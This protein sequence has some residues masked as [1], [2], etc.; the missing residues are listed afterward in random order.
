MSTNYTYA[1]DDR[2]E[3]GDREAPL[4]FCTEFVKIGKKQFESRVST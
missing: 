1:R 3:P 4:K 2:Q